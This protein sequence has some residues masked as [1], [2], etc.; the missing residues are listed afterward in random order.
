MG[1][2]SEPAALEALWVGAWPE[3]TPS[4]H[5]ACGIG[6]AVSFKKKLKE[7]NNRSRRSWG[8]NI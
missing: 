1:L 6:S 3:Q 8:K 4:P 5:P 7:K 2:S